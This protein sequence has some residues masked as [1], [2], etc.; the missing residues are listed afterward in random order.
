[1]FCFGVLFY[2]MWNVEFRVQ[3]VIVEVVVHRLPEVVHQSFHLLV[4]EGPV[5][6]AVKVDLHT[7]FKSQ[8]GDI[9]MENSLS[10]SNGKGSAHKQ[11]A[12]WQHLSQLKASA[13][14]SSQKI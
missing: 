11:S 3:S 5:W 8:F 2:R 7:C 1:M 13:F 9:S 14:S 6:N 12:R 4:V 10:L